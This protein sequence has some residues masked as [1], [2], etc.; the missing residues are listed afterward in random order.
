MGSKPDA[1]IDRHRSQHQQISTNLDQFFQSGAERRQPTYVHEG[2][3]RSRYPG[4]NSSSFYDL[5]SPNE[6]NPNAMRPQ[7]SRGTTE[8]KQRGH[9]PTNTP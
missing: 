4:K 7:I 9:L 5:S 6:E 8:G 2:S 3:K 1:Q